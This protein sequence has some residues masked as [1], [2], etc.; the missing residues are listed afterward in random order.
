MKI[1]KSILGVAGEFAV[2]TELCRRNIYAQLTLGNQKR[3]DLL[4]LSRDGVFVKIEAKAKQ[5]PM[6]PNQKGLPPGHGFIVFVDFAGRDDGAR[7]DFFVLSPDDW[8]AVAERHVA[9]YLKKHPDRTTH[10]DH[11]NCPLFPEEI[12]KHGKPYRGCSVRVTDVEPYREAWCK[13]I[14]ACK[15]VTSESAAEGEEV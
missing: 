1:E 6:W 14:D 4:A 12:N 2:A 11:E 3:V 13:I 8:R 15:L 10:L 7:P 9:E 5:G